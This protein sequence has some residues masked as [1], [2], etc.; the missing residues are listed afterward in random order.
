M[1]RPPP[2]LRLILLA[3]CLMV[4]LGRAIGKRGR[5]GKAQQGRGSSPPQLLLAEGGRLAEA[6]RLDE[7]EAAYAGALAADPRSTA[8]LG[9]RALLLPALGRSTEALDALSRLTAAAPSQP[10]A[11]Y[12]RGLVLAGMGRHSEAA[13]ALRRAAE[14]GEK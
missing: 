14:L 5:R 6:G 11:H 2:Q 13:P 4:C 9:N 1:A 12:N 10:S 8:A 7:A 3:T